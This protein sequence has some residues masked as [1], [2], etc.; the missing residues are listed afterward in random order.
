MIRALLFDMDGVVINS[1]PLYEKVQ[2]IGL[3]QYGVKL[4]ADDHHRFKGLSE[5]AVLDMLEQM[6][7]LQWDRDRL[8]HD[9]RRIMLQEFRANLEYMPGF[10]AV[11]E[12]IA[13]GFKRGLVTST[14]RVFLD[15]LDK[16]KPVKKYFPVIVA[17]GDVPNT[18]P[19]PAPYRKM[20]EKLRVRPAECVVIEDSI[21]GITSGKAAGART[22]ALSVTYPCERLNEADICVNSL[23][24]ITREMVDA[25]G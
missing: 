8:M 4:T 2:T 23:D 17:G 24:E 10:P 9:I 3:A 14:E 1:E 22:I 12:R 25:L 7:G 5:K 13:N 21:N 19:H 6:Y 15:E 16:I 18:K 20:M 11:L